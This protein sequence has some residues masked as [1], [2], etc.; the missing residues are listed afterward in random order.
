L[1]G[2]CVWS[3]REQKP[4]FGYNIPSDPSQDLAARGNAE[5]S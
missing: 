2:D 4:I 3:A 1:A 5:A